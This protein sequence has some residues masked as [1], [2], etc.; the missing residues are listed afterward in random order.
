MADLCLEA[1]LPCLDAWVGE[2]L[3]GQTE[4]VPALCSADLGILAPCWISGPEAAVHTIDLAK[5]LI[6]LCHQC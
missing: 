3:L 4:G 1:C 6:Q 5:L 2:A